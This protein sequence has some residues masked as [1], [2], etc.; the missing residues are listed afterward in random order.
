MKKYQVESIERGLAARTINVRSAA[1]R[2]FFLNTMKQPWPENFLPQVKTPKTLPTVF[3]PQ[4]VAQIL[5]HT[6]TLKQRAILA[7]MYSA[8]LRSFEVVNLK[9]KDINSQRMLIHVAEG[10]GRKERVTVLSQSLLAFLRSY[11][12]KWGHEN[13]SHWL[14]PSGYDARKSYATCSVRR[15]LRDAKEKAGITTAGCTHALRHSF[16]THLLE[17]GVDLRIIQILL[18]HVSISSTTIYT[19]L[20]GDIYQEIKNPLDKIA[21]K[22]KM[23]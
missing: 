6:Q 5:N 15:F 1:I 19:H 14:F 2:F 23:T 7:T 4:E 10:K 20:R 3:S 17:L 11:W 21:E 12:I 13:R 18:G 16:A 9:P 8:G 22:I